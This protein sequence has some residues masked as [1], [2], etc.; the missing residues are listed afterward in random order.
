MRVGFFGTPTFAART[1]EAVLAAGHEVAV[2]VAQPDRPQGRG[3]KLQS[4]PTI[5]LARAHGIPTLQPVRVKTGEFPEAI[6]ALN[7]DVA[8]VVAYGRILTPRLLAA[9]RRGC[10]NVH[11]SLLPRW[12]GAAPIQWSV[13]AGDA[14]TGVCTMQMDAGL[15]TG[16]VLL[17][18]ETPIGLEETSGQLH[19]RLAILGAELLVRTLAE[20]DTLTPKPQP[21]EGVTYAR[22]LEKGDSVLDWSRPAVDL[23]RQ[24][25]GLA[26]WPGTTTTFR[27][28]PL[29]VVRARTV[30]AASTEHAAAGTLHVDGNRLLVACGD[31]ALLELLEVQLPGKKSVGAH[32]FVHGSRVQTGEVLTAPPPLPTSPETTP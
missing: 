5:E 28:E 25:R 24:V 29:K 1:L 11:A 8:V 7:L 32:D 30:A 27:G 15:D 6:D 12:R 20:L 13:L 14:V 22:M 23:D 10:I 19:D 26:P 16:D 18:A 31:G 3:Q 4:P 2:V 21:T 9:P 17:R